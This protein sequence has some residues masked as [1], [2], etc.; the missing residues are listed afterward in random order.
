ML[1]TSKDSLHHVF[2]TVA[3][4]LRKGVTEDRH[5]F[6]LV[7]F[8]SQSANGPDVR[9]V[10]LREV[11]EHLG[12][13]IFTDSRS[14]K[15][16]QLNKNEQVALLFYHPEKRTQIRI[17]GTVSLHH[18]DRP[19]KTFWATLDRPSQ[20]G[21]HQIAAP[22]TTISK[23]EEAYEWDIHLADCHFMVIRV[24]PHEIWALQLDGHTH[25]RAKFVRQGETWTKTWMAP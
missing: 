7:S 4:E 14:N 1:F 20:Q 15:I 3:A 9:C 16:G 11:D 23:P 2:E 8:A 10:V 12:L 19:S 24:L 18:Q 21:Y 5:P 6:R 17:K 22:G 25:V 13:Y